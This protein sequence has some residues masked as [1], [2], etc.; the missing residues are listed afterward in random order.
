MNGLKR[1]EN[2]IE[3]LIHPII[4]KLAFQFGLGFDYQFPLYNWDYK[5]WVSEKIENG[6]IDECDI[7]FDEDSEGKYTYDYLENVLDFILK[8]KGKKINIEC[9]G[10]ESDKEQK[11]E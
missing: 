10:K 7:E 5:D 3:K 1:E 8:G 4:K 2:E 6:E 9:D 11:N